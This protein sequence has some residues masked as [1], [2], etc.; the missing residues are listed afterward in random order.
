MPC[1]RRRR[2][3]SRDSIH[4]WS[5]HALDNPV[6]VCDPTRPSWHASTRPCSTPVPP[7]TSGCAPLAR[8]EIAIGL[9][10][11]FTRF[12]T[13]RLVVEPDQLTHI[14]SPAINGLVDLPV[15]LT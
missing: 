5:A 1:Q 6:Y 7:A 12:P 3:H 8:Q 9:E 13:L 15:F 11:L 14:F 2:R 4:V 10:R